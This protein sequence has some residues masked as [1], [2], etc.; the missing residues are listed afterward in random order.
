MS[1]YLNAADLIAAKKDAATLDDVVNGSETLNGDGT[2]V[3]RK[4]RT[5]KTLA[6][7]LDDTT[8]TIAEVLAKTQTAEISAGIAQAA[9]DVAL[10]NSTDYDSLALA[11]AGAVNGDFFV[12]KDSEGR[13]IYARKSG[14]VITEIE[15]PWFSG[16]RVSAPLGT[17]VEQAL[18]KLPLSPV[19]DKGGVG[20]GITNDSAALLAAADDADRILIDTPL[21]I[22]STQFFDYTQS[23]EGVGRDGQV[24]IDGDA[25]FEN[26][27]VWR[28]NA[29]A[30]GQGTVEATRGL[31]ASRLR[32]LRINLEAAREAGKE[33]TFAAFGSG[34]IVDNVQV[35]GAKCAFRQGQDANSY[36][37]KVTFRQVHLARN[38]EQGPD[39][40][41]FNLPY[42][43]DGL[44]V[45]ACDFEHVRLGDVVNED[46]VTVRA[47]KVTQAVYKKTGLGLRHELS[48]NGLSW[49]D[50]CTGANIIGN[51][52]ENGGYRLSDCV[53]TLDGNTIYRR[54]NTLQYLNFDLVPVELVTG[55]D[56]NRSGLYEIKQTAI[57][58]WPN[59]KRGYPVNGFDL[60]VAGRLRAE[61]MHYVRWHGSDNGAVSD[62]TYVGV[63]A[64]LN[65]AAFEAF[66]N[67]S[68]FA[69][70][71]CVIEDEKLVL[72]VSQ[73]PASNNGSGLSAV[74]A[75]PL[76][77]KDK[78]APASRRVVLTANVLL[79]PI[80]RIGY[81]GTGVRTYDP[82]K[83]GQVPRLQ[84]ERRNGGAMF[85]IFE[86]QADGQFTKRFRVPVIVG[87]QLYYNGTDIC[88]YVPEDRT[89]GPVDGVNSDLMGGFTMEPG[90]NGAGPY[91]RV[92]VRTTGRLKP[93]AFGVWASGD[94]I[95]NSEGTLRFDGAVWRL[96]DGVPLAGFMENADLNLTDTDWNG[97][98][99]YA[100]GTFQQGRTLTL[101]APLR[102]RRPLTVHHATGD[103]YAINIFYNGQ[104]IGQVAGGETKTVIMNKD[105]TGY[106]V[107]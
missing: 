37:D 54:K 55:N 5:H 49:Y 22:I 10:A 61:I 81:K 16:S 51:H 40:W 91:G 65:G 8:G 60:K 80:R 104:T 74:D 35:T 73:G 92:R 97:G 85:E 4:G 82:V 56:L 18:R 47:E 78:W 79:D 23:V 9:R 103:A 99:V 76:S 15:D 95:W 36:T 32:N 39:D 21:K 29:T 93:P 44:L 88:G 42:L 63:R 13:P 71:R 67:Y 83:D 98:S 33:L 86:G 1:D 14:G 52:N 106:L 19:R 107:F 69:S 77:A 12:Y 6:R 25:A 53:A 102:G 46:G 70:A 11:Q 72:R 43:G 41:M 27:I 48:M 87:R 101:Q 20:D 57:P 17:T 58:Y 38:A 59:F 66:N 50:R 3:S 31:P 34:L 7:I 94:E 96:V 26:D 64:Q 90:D 68:H 45:Q 2:T 75:A 28:F 24:L 89:S 62:S 84:V 100:P 105:E 30:N